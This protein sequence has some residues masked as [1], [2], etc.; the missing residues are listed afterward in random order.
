[1]FAAQSRQTF[2]G[3]ITDDE[4]RRADHSGMRMGSTDT[5]CTIACVDDHSIRFILF[6]G[7]ETYRLSDQDKSR[8][9]AGKKVAVV[10]TLDSTTKTIQ[11]NSMAAAK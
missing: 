11:V 2:S 5:A 9:F 4:C 3:T 6:D 1:M 10:G 8:E 7:K